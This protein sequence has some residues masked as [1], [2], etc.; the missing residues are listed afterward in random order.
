[1]NLNSS[2]TVEKAWYSLKK[3]KRSSM[4]RERYHAGDSMRREHQCEG[5][6]SYRAGSEGKVYYLLAKGAHSG[7]PTC[8]ADRDA[9][10]VACLLF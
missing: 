8:G 6:S 3:R 2:I 1:V 10:K 4:S 5:F 9:S 7:K